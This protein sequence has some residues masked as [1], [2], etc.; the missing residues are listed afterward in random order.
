MGGG[1]RGSPH[2]A[3]RTGRD[4]AFAVERLA[5]RIDHPPQPV[6][7]DAQDGAG[8]AA[9][10]SDGKQGA[11]AGP[12]SGERAQRHRLRGAIAEADDFRRDVQPLPALQQQP[13]ADAEQAG[14]AR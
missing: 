12:D 1:R 8:Q 7:A 11:C 3:G 5:K 14:Q 6:V 13:V 9:R 4:G 10:R 2:R